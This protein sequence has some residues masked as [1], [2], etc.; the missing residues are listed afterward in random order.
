MKTK[1]FIAA[2][3]LLS[4]SF[5]MSF[6]K[7][8]AQKTKETI[9][10]MSTT[11]GDIKLKLYNETPKHRDNFI[12]LVNE[13]YYDST[14]FHRVIQG[15]MIQGGDPN[16]RK[17]APGVMLGNGETGYTIPAEFNPMLFHKKG[18]LAAARQGDEVNPKK[19]SSGCQFYIVQG[20]PCTNADL[21]NYESRMKTK[22]TPEQRK[23]YTTI[24]GTPHLDGN[25]TVYGEV[26]EGLDVVDKIAATPVDQMTRPVKDV[27]IIKAVIVK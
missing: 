18:V 14:L 6:K 8:E 25:Y 12:K 1:F 27:R 15:F 11:L 7:K 19:E 20:K 24:G 5:L 9:I 13:H 26:I 2:S 21:D 10:L 23:A 4:M 3:F 17:A 16:S 22:F